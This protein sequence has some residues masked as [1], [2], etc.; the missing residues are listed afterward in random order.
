[1]TKND[2]LK[3]HY[4]GFCKE[5]EM[6]FVTKFIT[7]PTIEKEYSECIDTI[8]NITGEYNTGRGMIAYNSKYGQG[9]SFFFEVFNHYFKRHNHGQ[10]A[11]KVVTAKELV[12]IYTSAKNGEDGKHKLIEAI[13]AK[14]LFID[15]IGDEGTN[16]VFK[17]YGNELNVLRF[18]LLHRY[19]MWLEKGWITFGTTNL[20]IQ[21]IG[22]NY[23]GRLSDRILQMCYWREFKFLSEGSFRQVEETRRLTMDEI[24]SSW[25][26]LRV[27]SPVE[28]VD[29]EKYFN[30]L[31]N[32]DDSYFQH[33]DDLFWKFVKDYLVEKGLLTQADFDK[34]DEEALEDA[35][36]MV[37][38]ETR[39][40]TKKRYKHAPAEN[41]NI[42]IQE[43]LRN[44]LPRQ[45]MNHAENKIAR[46][47]FM[48]LRITKHKFE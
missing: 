10:N 32:E 15:D 18:V 31:I 37:K 24:K 6:F 48:E 4:Q 33:K 5:A 28:K 34:I 47:K 22:V 9:K 12:G 26:S 27:E 7:S 41:R 21:Q 17:H 20:S 42:N 45:I 40:N 23:D 30:E 44:I 29:L 38:F 46:K 35:E 3:R 36:A 8:L 2:L 25:D 19:E 13:S 1:M 14:R 39:E 16:K 11:F 43:A